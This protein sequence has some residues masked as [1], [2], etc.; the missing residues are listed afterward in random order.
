MLTQPR[1]DVNLGLRDGYLVISEKQELGLGAC[2]CR[3]E[4]I[5]ERKVASLS[6]HNY[7]K[8]KGVSAAPPG[9]SE[10]RGSSP[11]TQPGC[12]TGPGLVEQRAERSRRVPASLLPFPRA[13]GPGGG[14][15]SPFFFF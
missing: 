1:R 3:D 14:G 10:S 9:P 13:S 15:E 7:L 4:K 5:V 12:A 6:R 2:N 11:A 8:S